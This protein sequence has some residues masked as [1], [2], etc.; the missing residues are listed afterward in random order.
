MKYLLLLLMGLNL[1]GAN[2]QD[3]LN[4]LSLNPIELLGYNRLNIEFERGFGQGKM[5]IS[6]Y[7]G[8]TGVASRKIH[9]EFSQ[10]SEESVA[11]RFFTKAIDKSSYW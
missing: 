4:K 11:V 2:A 1:S 9:D 7:I 10:L 6:L 3:K 8:H 5:G